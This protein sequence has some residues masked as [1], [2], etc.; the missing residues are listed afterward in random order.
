M[1]TFSENIVK[2]TGNIIIK[3]TSDNSII[4]TI[5]VTTAV[6]SISGAEATINPSSDLALNTEFYVQIAA[7]AFKDAA[8][9]SY[10]GIADTTTWSFT[11]QA[12]QT[13]T[14]SGATDT[15]WATITNWSLGRTPISTDN[16]I[17]ADVATDPVVFSGTH[18]IVNDV[19][20]N[21]S[22]LLTIT[23]GAD[24]TINGNSTNNGTFNI[25]SG[26]SLIVTGTST[27]N[28]TYKRNLTTTNWYLISSPVVGV[29]VQD[30]FDLGI[31][32]IN[33]FKFSFA[34]YVNDGT[35][36]SYGEEALGTVITNN[37]VLTKG[38]SVRL[39]SAGD[40]QFTG[41]MPTTDINIAITDGAA[42]EFNLIGNPYPSYV[43]ANTNADAVNN[44]LTV[45]TAQLQ[46]N[47]LWFW[48]QS[49]SSY[50]TVNQASA[51]KFIPP[52]QGFFVNAKL[53]GGTFAFTEAMQSHQATDVFS[54][55]TNNRFEINLAMT[56]GTATKNTEIYYINGTNTAFDNGYDSSI[57]SGT[58][59]AFAVYTQ[60]VSD[61]QGRKLGI[62]SLPDANYENMMIPV[63]VNA[64][65]GTEITFSI[66]AQNIPT[67]LDIYLENRT[68]NTFTKL[69]DNGNYT[70]ILDADSNG[71]GQFYLR[72][73]SSALG[74]ETVTLNGVSMYTT[75]KETLRIIG[76]QTGK[77][78]VKMFTLLGKQVLQTTFES[79]GVK[80]VKLPELS[81]GVYLINLQTATGTLTKK[82]IIQ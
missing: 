32:A 80:D 43:P 39:A 65:A 3:K 15:N 58:S 5:D 11:T 1:L 17:I 72:T 73:S 78:S 22:G 81:A 6:V 24:I 76:L 55:T 42:N 25:E 53:G 27:G 13:N 60:T 20:I 23:G 9:N 4:E 70:I 14:W 51:S 41:T 18:T 69:N 62:Q 66:A 74:L 47:T 21:A 61:S 75:N 7:T 48:D 10:A 59:N 35:S 2:G 12:N 33:G 50:I 26:G 30:L 19:T 38:Y 40:I 31:F 8:T 49:T 79:T 63:G 71:V 64:V 77:A 34:L 28:I 45:N 44:I 57:F 67:G 68:D 52:A 54:R 16:V 36:W 56:D 29:T 37:V 46:E 82:I